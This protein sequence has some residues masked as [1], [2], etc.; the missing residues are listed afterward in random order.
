MSLS[1][2]ASKV[3]AI[4]PGPNTRRSPAACNGWVRNRRDGSVEAV[5][6]GAGRC[7]R[8]HGRS[9][10]DRTGWRPVEAV[11]QREARPDEVKLRRG[12]ELFSVLSNG[13]SIS[14]RAEQRLERRTQRHVHFR[15]RHRH[16]E[17]GERGDA[18]S[19]GR[20]RRTAR[21]RKNATSSG[22]TLSAKPCSV[23]QCRT[24]MPMAAILSSNFSPLS[25]RGT[26]TPIRSS[27]RSPRT[28]KD[29]SVRM[30]HSSIDGDEAAHIRRAAL[31]IEHDIADALARPVI[32]ELAAAAGHVDRKARVDQFGRLCRGAGGVKGRVLEQPDQLGAPR[33]ARSPR[34]VQS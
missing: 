33:R 2:A 34:P 10:P 22:S 27:R 7:R 17:I 24:R 26:Q 3:S 30:I 32:G 16:A 21:C 14:R 19:A 29:A 8:R 20:R 11:D 25:G 15:H 4:A 18:D 23:T 9:L 6:I 1:A 5:F 13:L 12:D 31:E 28:L